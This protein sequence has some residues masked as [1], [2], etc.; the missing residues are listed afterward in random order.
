MAGA[1]EN[2][3]RPDQP[4]TAGS[5]FEPVTWQQQL[6]NYKNL[7]GAEGAWRS[8]DG[9]PWKTPEQG[10][11]T[12]AIGKA[13]ESEP[14]QRLMTLSMFLGPGAKT[15]NTAALTKAQGMASSG[16]PR[17]QILKETGW[18]AGPDKKWRFEIDD[19]AALYRGS[20]AA[21][22]SYADD[23][24]NHPQLFEAYPSLGRS[25]VHEGPV[26]AERSGSFDELTGLTLNGRDK[27]QTALHELQHG[28][29]GKE[30][31]ARGGNPES[32]ASISSPESW[33]A[34]LPY[35]VR[36]TLDE[37]GIGRLFPFDPRWPSMKETLRSRIESDLGQPFKFGQRGADMDMAD[38]AL[39]MARNYSPDQ[40]RE[41]AMN[42]LRQTGMDRY[43][44]L[45]GE[46]EARAVE[47]RMGLTPEQ[48]SAR[49][50]WLDYDVPE[51]QMII[52]WE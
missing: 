43:R 38:F 11:F 50:P 21:G 16:L 15:A 49:P 7:E 12:K 45:A 24:I 22:S 25:R 28:V 46:V 34:R 31:F 37:A 4:Q 6:G 5:A 51:A 17:E 1:F 18:F 10:A 41:I 14:G 13:L 30:G 23:V 36:Q 48:R 20:K 44:R 35:V 8:A 32:F 33:N 26:N 39:E 3:M 2:F 27:M 19:S 9:S 29:Q 52:K 47:S 42:G 40:L